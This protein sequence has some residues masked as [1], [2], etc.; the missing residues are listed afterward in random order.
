M[1]SVVKTVYICVSVGE[2]HCSLTRMIA[3]KQKREMLGGGDGKAISGVW[4]SGH[5]QGGEHC[6]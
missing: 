4:S 3:Q 6:F 1:R 2:G 5:G